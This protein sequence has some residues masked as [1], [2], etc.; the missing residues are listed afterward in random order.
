MHTIP[1]GASPGTIEGRGTP[2]CNAPWRTRSLQRYFDRQSQ[3]CM[4]IRRC[5]KLM[6]LGCTCPAVMPTTTESPCRR[7]TLPSSTAMMKSVDPFLS[8]LGA[9]SARHS[10]AE[11][12]RFS[13]ESV[14]LRNYVVVVCVPS[15]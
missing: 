8:V 7:N 13:A 3:R 12:A 6:H 4:S 15:W 2:G 9:H 5:T 14:A 10:I 1:F 11:Q